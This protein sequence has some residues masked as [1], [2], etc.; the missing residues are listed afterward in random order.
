[1]R[2]NLGDQETGEDSGDGYRIHCKN[3]ISL[4][5]EKS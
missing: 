1:M 4:S 2:T 5:E 3:C